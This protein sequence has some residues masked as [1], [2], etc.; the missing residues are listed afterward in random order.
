M[1]FILTVCVSRLFNSTQK[2]I[3]ELISTHFCVDEIKQVKTVLC[4]LVNEEFQERRSTDLRTDKYA[5]SKDMVNILKNIDKKC[6]PNF[7]IDSYGLVKLPR[8]NQEDLSFYAVS[9][10]LAE[11]TTQFNIFCMEVHDNTAHIKLNENSIV[12]IVGNEGESGMA[13]LPSAPLRA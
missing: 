9:E 11:L 3:I 4:D 2:K 6:M 1:N 13:V 7:V 10:K 5:H 8:I 12:S